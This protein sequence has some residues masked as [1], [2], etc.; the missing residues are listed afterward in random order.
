MKKLFAI[1]F[2]L[3]SLPMWA[4]IDTGSRQADMEL[5]GFVNKNV[6]YDNSE[7]SRYLNEAFVPAKINRSKKTHLVRFNVVENTIEVKRTDSKIMSL[8]ES[9]N[10]FIELLDGSNKIYVTREYTD[11]NGKLKTTF[12]EEMRDTDQYALYMKE[13][14]IYVRPQETKTHYEQSKYGKF[15]AGRTKF[16][17]QEKN[18]EFSALKEIPKKKKA[19]LSL[20]GEHAKS[21]EQF[22]KKEKVKTDNRADISKIL[23]HY[24]TL[25]V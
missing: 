11:D 2:C 3:L 23:D 17:F 6:E 20:F 19:F 16:Y 25:K 13:Q 24:F 9:N 7:G 4:Q 22:L 8:S 21:M 18:T 15:I 10:Y 1:L 14:I 5:A 12:F